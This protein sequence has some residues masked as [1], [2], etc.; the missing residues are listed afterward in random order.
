M[1]ELFLGLPNC[2]TCKK[3]QKSLNENKID[4]VFRDIKEENP[5]KEEL[6]EWIARSGRPIKT[7]FSPTGQSYR[8]LGLKDT[9]HD[10]TDEQMIEVLAS[11][12]MLIK[13]PL[14]IGQHHA[15]VG[16]REMQYSTWHLVSKR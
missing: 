10:M 13:R 6:T 9:I 5:T 15:L 14:L 11:D 4:Y 7:F 8:S 2:N 16:Y 3:A 1:P 12:G